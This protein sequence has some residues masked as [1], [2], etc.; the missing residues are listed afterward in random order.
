MTL[1]DYQLRAVDEIRT[2]MRTHRRV[3]YVLP[4]GGGKTKVGQSV[5]ELAVAK[6]NRVL[7]LAHRRELVAQAAKRIE[8]AGIIMAGIDATESPIQVASIDTLN[9]RGDRPPADL[10]IVDEC[11]HATAESWRDVIQAYPKAFVLG[12][13]ATPER[14]DGVALGN[15]FTAL[16]PGPSVPDLIDQNYLVD[17]DVIAPDQNRNALACEP[18]EAWTKWARRGDAG[19]VFAKTIE[20]SKKLASEFNAN[21]IPARHVDGET[22]LIARTDAIKSFEAGFVN[23]LTSVYVF[24]EG[25]D[26][27]RA[28]VCMLARNCQGAGTFLQMVGRVLRPYPTKHRALLIDLVGAVHTHGLP[29]DERTYSLDGKAISS[30]EALPA[31][32]QCAECGAVWRGASRECPRCKYVLPPPEEPK[33]RPREMTEYRRPIRAHAP[34][35]ERDRKLAEWIKIAQER[36]YKRGWVI[37]KYQSV[38]GT[39]PPGGW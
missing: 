7:W 4:T 36:G 15:I 19:F 31:L 37:H 39:L 13:T 34:Q 35:A 12:L 26:L 27:P 3:V 20:Q 25:V 11:H 16:I 23:V 33:V 10:I 8:N 24:T 17:C 1:R 6:G 21:G 9:A 30:V 5:A 18:V 32:T 38:Y 22:N 2:T 28:R 29:T 14:G